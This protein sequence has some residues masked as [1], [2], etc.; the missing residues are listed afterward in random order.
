M[1]APLRALVVATKDPFPPIGGGNLVLSLLLESL[2]AAGV[3]LRV[4]AP[5]GRRA[6]PAHGA[7]YHLERVPVAPRPWPW[8][9]GHLLAG[10]S[11]LVARYRL[12]ALAQAVRKELHDFAPDLVHI[13]QVHLGWLVPPLA[14]RTPV[15]LRQQNVE[16]DLLRQLAGF[17]PPG[18]AWLLRREARALAAFEAGVC[19][20]A[21][22]V[23]VISEP[24]A[25]LLRR[26]APQAHIELLPPIAPAPH[27]GVHA[28]LASTPA[29]LCIGSF[30]WWPNR[31]GGRWLVR[32]VWPRLRR[33]L[34][35]AALHLAG[36][37]SDA[38]GRGTPGI[39]HHGVVA[40]SAS[41]YDPRA[42]ALIP[43]RAASGARIRLLEAWAAGVPVVSTSVGI[44][45]L[46]ACDGDGALVADTPT[47]FADAAQRLAA[48]VELRAA[49]I[50]RGRSRLSAFSAERVAE[51][52]L[53]LYQATCA[54]FQQ[55]AVRSRQALGPTC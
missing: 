7:R 1:T 25:Q 8:L 38:L 42:T 4:V 55:S 9:T 47:A 20:Q 21:H 44:R 11:A 5:Q 14:E 30:D 50:E 49:L 45:G 2:L 12:P 37:G 10:R 36:P 17:A 35:G 16:S 39:V 28:Q 26:A 41:L 40:A 48:D 54:R 22:T 3:E 6:A 18:T 53:A 13:E 24:D 34:P 23:A 27:A 31:D 46:A 33:L 19:Q 43:V 15:L 32:A 52:A 51:R 29:F